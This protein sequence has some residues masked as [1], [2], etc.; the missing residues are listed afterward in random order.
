MNLKTAFLICNHLL[1]RL[2]L[3]YANRGEFQSGDQ[4]IWKPSLPHYRLGI[5]YQHQGENSK[6][7]GRLKQA[8][9]LS[10]KL[11]HVHQFRGKLY[12]EI[13][14]E[15]KSTFHK[16]SVEKISAKNN[17]AFAITYLIDLKTLGRL[18]PTALIMPIAPLSIRK[19]LWSTRR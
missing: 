8:F 14:Q 13:G 9:L 18:S 7:I 10:S 5:I 11:R 15:Q 1:T 16:R 3:A 2:A 4:P 19:M 6:A 17:E 12:N